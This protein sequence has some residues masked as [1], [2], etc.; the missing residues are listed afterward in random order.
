MN[1]LVTLVARRTAIIRINA[2]FR[3]SVRTAAG[4]H[5]KPLAV[6]PNV[7]AVCPTLPDGSNT[8]QLA[9]SSLERDFFCRRLANVGYLLDL[10]I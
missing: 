6:A 10:P 3:L 2:A 5:V 8:L 4:F 9:T 7:P 1:D